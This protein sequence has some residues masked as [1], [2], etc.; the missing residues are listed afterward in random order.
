MIDFSLPSRSGRIVDTHV[1]AD[2]FTEYVVIMGALCDNRINSCSWENF[3][4]RFLI[5]KKLISATITRQTKIMMQNFW[6]KA[7]MS[8]MESM[9]FNQIWDL[10]EPP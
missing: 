7:M 1:T 6:Q 2:A 4:T 3:L 10:V 9:Y 8:E 5:N